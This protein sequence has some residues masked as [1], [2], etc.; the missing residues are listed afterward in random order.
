MAF[1]LAGAA[2]AQTP[3]GNAEAATRKTS[4]CEGCHGVPG[5]RTAS[6]HVY[7][8]PKLGGQ[9]ALYLINALQQYKS[10]AR[11][12]PTMGAVAQGLS[13]QD[14]ADIAAYYSSLQKK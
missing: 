1:A 2:L 14:M 9:Q 7:R 8:V 5:Y 13:E 4:M 3:A 11:S 12:H 6:P 10:G